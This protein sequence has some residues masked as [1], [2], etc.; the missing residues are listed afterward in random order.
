MAREAQRR[1]RV[2]DR[3]GRLEPQTNR[4]TTWVLPTGGGG[5]PA[6]PARARTSRCTARGPEP[7]RSTQ[8]RGDRG[9]RAVEPDAVDAAGRAGARAA[10]A[11]PV[12]CCGAG[13][14]ATVA[15]GRPPVAGQAPGCR[16]FGRR[17]GATAA[18]R[19]R[20]AE[21]V[22]TRPSPGRGARGSTTARWAA[23]A[24][25]R[26]RRPRRSP[27]RATSM[28]AGA[29][30][31]VGG[32]EATDADRRRDAGQGR[33]GSAARGARAASSAQD[34]V[35]PGR[36]VGRHRLGVAGLGEEAAY[37]VVSGSGLGSSSRCTS[38][39]VHGSWVRRGRVIG[40]P[41]PS[42]GSG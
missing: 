9:C 14:D 38:F 8:E 24:G 28:A 20:S 26:P 4:S 30:P 35:H 19:R 5:R 33:A 17:A 37:R 27:R 2:A 29:A 23:G 34:V 1:R 22:D 40:R 6:P 25:R 15:D 21:S 31:A 32:D 11:S 41:G 7:A 42:G 13:R 36:H 18:R 16:A 12:K 10:Q 39:V 3:T